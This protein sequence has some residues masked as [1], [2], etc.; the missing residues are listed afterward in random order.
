MT[1][2][3]NEKLVTHADGRNQ[4]VGIASLYGPLHSRKSG[5][6]E[7]A[8]GWLLFPAS[9]T[10]L[11]AAPRMK[12]VRVNYILGSLVLMSGFVQIFLVSSNSPT[13]FLELFCSGPLAEI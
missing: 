4:T 9:V 10:R 6:K 11:G 3:N 2:E 5:F 8:C 12:V 7:T 1:S 13:M